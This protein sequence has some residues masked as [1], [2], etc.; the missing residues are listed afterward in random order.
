VQYLYLTEKYPNPRATEGESICLWLINCARDIYICPLGKKFT[1]IFF[2][3]KL[4]KYAIIRLHNLKL[5]TDMAHI[6]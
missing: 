5:D 6:E 1:F 2:K 4:R 3:N